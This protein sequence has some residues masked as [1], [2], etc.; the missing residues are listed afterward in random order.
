MS[1]RKYED[2]SGKKFHKLTVL[3]FAGRDKWHKVLW[4][5]QCDCGN[6]TVTHARSLKNGHT[7]SCGCL[8]GDAGGMSGTRIYSI[9]N[10][11]I[12]RCNNPRQKYHCGKGIKVCDEWS[13]K[14]GFFHFK[15]WA[16]ANGYQEDLTIDRID[17][18]G[19]YEP[20]NCR[21]VDWKTQAAN[22]NR[23]YARNQYGKWE[24]KKEGGKQ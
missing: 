15:D 6:T 19:N 17:N 21:W 23:T 8:Q 9:W 7:K 13:V 12:Q 4:K 11:M 1:P 22:V 18:D 2:L 3:E 16:L 10:S 20:S 14:G 5:C 24:I